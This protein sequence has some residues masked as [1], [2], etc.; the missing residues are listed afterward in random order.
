M[1]HK[2]FWC[3]GRRPETTARWR[4]LG[5]ELRTIR[6]GRE[7][8]GHEMARRTGWPVSN[9]SR[10]ETG[11]RPMSAV[12]AAIYLATCGVTGEERERLLELTRPG[13]EMYWVRPYFDKLVDPLKSLI[14]QENLAEAIVSF[15]PMLIPG[16]RQIEP[17]TRALIESNPRHTAERAD[18]LVGARMNRQNPLDR[19]NPPSCTFFIHE[20]ALRSVVGDPSVMHEQVLRLQLAHGMPRCSIRVVPEAVSFFRT[21][22][23]PFKIMA[24]ADHP[25]VAHTGTFAAS[26]FMD[27]RAAVEGY[28]R[29]VAQLEHDALSEG[30]SHQW[31]ARSA[32]EYERMKE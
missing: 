2:G 13:P 5:S 24:F 31:L 15:E 16:L 14:I 29:L 18:V 4:E 17:Y 11:L 8:S 25:A 21:F 23:E 19:R 12:E 20:R 1:A 9:V 6:Q 26:L 10:W 22:V 32:G 27:A 28:Y 30:Q 7:S 3:R